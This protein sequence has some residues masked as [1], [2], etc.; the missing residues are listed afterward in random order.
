MNENIDNKMKDDY[1]RICE[2]A[3]HAQNLEQAEVA[4]FYLYLM[5]EQLGLDNTG[6]AL[7]CGAPQGAAL[8]L[9]Q[10]A[11]WTGV[12]T[13][14]WASPCHVLAFRPRPLRS[15]RGRLLKVAMTAVE[16]RPYAG[17]AVTMGLDQV[18]AYVEDLHRASPKNTQIRPYPYY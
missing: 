3:Y 12:A 1:Q 2:A 11:L 9:V 4:L 7:R 17:R 6:I 18:M 14:L 13:A 10:E 8:P 5:C 16:H 15:F